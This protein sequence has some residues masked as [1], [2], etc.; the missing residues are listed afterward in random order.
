M[1]V[2]ASS[3]NE[4]Y[5]YLDL[6]LEQLSK[7]KIS[8]ALGVDQD[9][10]R[11]PGIISLITK[12]DIKAS[13]AKNIDDILR[14]VPE[15]RVLEGPTTRTNYIMR[16]SLHDR[17]LFMINGIAIKDQFVG[18]TGLVWKGL[19]V[20]S[21]KRIE[22]IRG[23]ASTTYG[24]DAVSGAINIITKSNDDIETAQIGLSFGDFN[25]Q[26][27]WLSV[28]S[29]FKG[30]KSSLTL[31]YNETDGY[32]A[33]IE[34]DAQT[35]LDKVFNTNASQAPGKIQKQWQ[36]FD[37][38][39]DI[40]KDQW[41]LRSGYI[42]RKNVGMGVG[43]VNAL[44][45]YGRHTDK[46]YNLD[47]TFH[48][49]NLTE[50]ISLTSVLSYIGT[51]L[52]Y[53]EF[54]RIYPAGAFGGAYPDGLLSGGVIDERH[55]LFNAS[56]LY[57]G[58][59]KHTIRAGAG[60]AIDEIINVVHRVNSGLDRNGIPI[61]AGSPIVDLT[62]SN[63]TFLPEEKRESN[64]IFVQDIW[65]IKNN[66]E[67]TLGLRHDQFSDFGDAT[68]PRIALFWQLTQKLS[69]K[70]LYGKSFKSPTFQELYIRN[71]P[72]FKGNPDLKP[73]LASTTE[74]A[75]NYQAAANLQLN[76]N[77]YNIR[78]TDSIE[79][80]ENRE[81][82]NIG[83]SESNGFAFEVKWQPTNRLI[84]SGN[85]SQ[86]KV[87]GKLINSGTTFTS[88]HSAYFNIDWKI[89]SNWRLNIRNNWLGKQHREIGDSRANIAPYSLV[90]FNVINNTYKNWQFSLL[91]KNIFDAD[92][93]DAEDID[94][95]KDLPLQG[96][97]LFFE[98]S[99][100]F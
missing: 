14:S 34:E 92:A 2:I 43:L 7:V 79:S 29:E 64:F 26:Q 84:V 57:M 51:T 33:I 83:K 4:D 32:D 82:I 100:S 54:H 66:L 56:V 20:N 89:T 85:F 74:L 10:Q 97:S 55:M 95:P 49:P 5:S 25:S 86:S 78:N 40:Q 50:N 31:E 58:I 6:S 44:D 53:E 37:V 13:G 69:A 99:Y 16:G 38:R 8:I 60:L 24:A 76:F 30:F 65:T 28:K 96:R 21:I 47:L 94:L 45:P 71:S 68:T 91:G 75:F 59:E 19:P 39:L 88:P 42:D 22:I 35:E 90:D 67:L 11:A 61:P 72:V 62:G 41:H 48:E 93:R 12:N 36:G 63:F 17:L 70:F 18:S 9:Q 87:K 1:S 23:P 98:A 80:N 81:Y 27:A 46:R 77:I 3:T 15:L 52:G 73:E